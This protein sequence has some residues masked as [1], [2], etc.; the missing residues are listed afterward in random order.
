MLS[1]GF[2]HSDIGHALEPHIS[3]NLRADEGRA[4]AW[5]AFRTLL[6]MNPPSICQVRHGG[7]QY[8]GSRREG[9]NEKV[10]ARRRSKIWG[11]DCI[12]ILMP[13]PFPQQDGGETLIEDT[14][15]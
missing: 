8:S 7:N 9:A 13:R 15:L 14:R 3:C 12:V 10:T 6:E 1:L 2:G 5:L 11:P 4:K